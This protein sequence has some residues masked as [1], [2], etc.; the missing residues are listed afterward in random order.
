M[1]RFLTVVL[2]TCVGFVGA[3]RADTPGDLSVLVEKVS[4]AVVNI[5][6]TQFVKTRASFETYLKQMS[7]PQKAGS[8]VRQSS[9]GTGF[10]VASTR[11][12]PNTPKE[13][14]RPVLILTNR[15]VVEDAASIEI[16]TRTVRG[17]APKTYPAQL[18]A[19]DA[20]MDLAVLR[21]QLPAEIEPLALGDSDAL[22]PGS[23]VF[24]IGNPFGLGHTVTAGILS[25]KDRTLGLSRA[26]RYLQTDAAIN[27]GNSGGPLF[28]VRGEVIGMNTLV[29]VDAQGIGFAIPANQIKKSLPVLETSGHVDH[30]WLGLVAENS[31]TAYR[32]F[33]KIRADTPGV[34]VTHLVKNGPAH[35]VGLE[36][37]DFIYAASANGQ[38]RSIADAG[39]LRD[40]SDDLKPGDKVELKVL[41]KERE[42]LAKFE[43]AVVPP[44]DK[45]PDG[46]EFF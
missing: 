4:P 10:V 35:K 28:N 39:A 19:I 44:T 14:L 43:P 37:G 41:R 6:A 22:N 45:L 8:S 21:A 5:Q 27:F 13:A 34:V 2:A 15:H 42:F 1:E 31:T 12:T 33:F 25:A 7:H 16:Q 30:A 29:R 26:D 20:R 18:V 23:S 17:S 24:A 46:Y 40:F 32:N 3:A 9:L 11:K 36:E 38:A